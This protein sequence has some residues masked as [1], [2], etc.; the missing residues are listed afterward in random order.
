M[1]K[2]SDN[3]ELKVNVGLPPKQRD[4]SI[5]ACPCGNELETDVEPARAK[6][7]KCGFC[8]EVKWTQR[9]AKKALSKNLDAPLEMLAEREQEGDA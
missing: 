6:T 7:F 1:R 5:F 2:K 9:Q 4:I 3:I 8:G